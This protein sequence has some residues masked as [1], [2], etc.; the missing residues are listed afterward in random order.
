VQ[1]ALRL[2]HWR[3]AAHMPRYIESSELGKQI[4]LWTA[5][6]PRESLNEL[7]APPDEWAVS[8]QT[9]DLLSNLVTRLRPRSVLEFG[10]GRSSLVLAWSLQQA[11]G[12]RL[13]S[14]EHQPTYAE[15]AWRRMT[16]FPDVDAS[17]VPATLGVRLSRHGL[18]YQYLGVEDALNK[19]GLFD[20]VFIDAPPGHLGRD[21]T[22]FAAAPF[23]KAGAVVV[24]DDSKRPRE[25]TAT[26]R[27][28]RG[29]HIQRIFESDDV[30]RGV[31]VL[32]VTDPTPTAF[33][34]RTF[35]G[36]IHDRLLEFQ[37]SRNRSAPDE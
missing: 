15:P 16:A 33:S 29:L 14:I 32:K 36:T 21:G 35:A 37:S 22:L 3:L 6:P 5:G 4:A 9:A 20:F 27:W 28:E 2:I 17:L 30:G 19:R 8:L 18:L 7:L 25:Q 1:L 23:L 24:L 11:G 10:A 13:T 12:G 31:A 26:R 34:F